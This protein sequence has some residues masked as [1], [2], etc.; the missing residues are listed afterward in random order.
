MPS[1][2]STIKNIDFLGEVTFSSDTQVKDTKLGG[3]SGITYDASKKVY[4]SI[5]D[6]RSQKAPARFYTLTINLDTKSLKEVKFI[7]VTLLK[8]QRRQ[9]FP[10]KSIDPEGIALTNKNT[11]YISSEGDATVNNL[12][13]P[14][15]NEFSLTGEQLKALPISAKYLPTY[16]QTRGI[17]NN[18]AFESLTITPSQNYLITATENALAQD[19]ALA[20]VNNGSPARIVSYNLATGTVAEY[21]YLTDK[22]AKPPTKVGGFNN[23]G[24][25][26]LLA[27][28]DTHLLGL[29]RSFS[30]GAGST[31]KLY[32]VSLEGAEDISDIDS[33]KAVDIRKINSARKKLLFDFDKLN[34]TLEN[35]EGLTFGPNLPDGRRSLI[36]VSDNNFS[37]NQFTQ[38]L[39]FSV[40]IPKPSTRAD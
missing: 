14:F 38:L 16:W 19:G 34:I 27:I 18:F 28:D 10:E 13:N 26:D 24:L 17:R 31:I 4:Y 9:N 15:V 6:D 25:V 30:V 29:E 1:K 12:T 2:A 35:I 20:T 5:S 3:L 37:S 39:A 33:L 8:N 40:A 23:S 36:V 22:V 7:D 32:E 11:L 21:L